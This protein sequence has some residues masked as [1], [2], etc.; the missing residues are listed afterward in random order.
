MPDGRAGRIALHVGSGQREL[1]RVTLNA[2]Q[3]WRVLDKDWPAS[4]PL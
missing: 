2:E 3:R 1:H 4:N